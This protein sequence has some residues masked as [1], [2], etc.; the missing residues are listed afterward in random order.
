MEPDWRPTCFRNV[1]SQTGRTK[2]IDRSH[3][4]E[5]AIGVLQSA[6]DLYYP[7]EHEVNLAYTWK[8][9]F[10]WVTAFACVSDP[11]KSCQSRTHLAIA[12]VN[13]LEE[14]KGAGRHEKDTA[15]GEMECG[16]EVT[17][18]F[19]AALAPWH[20]KNIDAGTTMK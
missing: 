11:N 10:R 16:L 12:Q 19:G 4:E 17:R 7:D 14:K 8:K 6:F 2:K 18:S 20:C 3:P 1:P 9:K 5:K 13:D 15:Y